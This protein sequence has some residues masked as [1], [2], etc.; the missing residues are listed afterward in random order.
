MRTKAILLSILL[1]AG[2]AL[3]GCP[4]T[5]ETTNI[6]EPP[7]PPPAPPTQVTCAGSVAVSGTSIDYADRSDAEPAE[8]KEGGKVVWQLRKSSAAVVD[9]NVTSFGGHGVF[10]PGVPPDTYVVE[11]VATAKDGTKSDPC[12]YSG[13]TVTEF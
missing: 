10:G 9:S 12:T 2:L 8:Q 3:G 6:T 13:L 1:V 4:I 5:E 11:Q 7:P